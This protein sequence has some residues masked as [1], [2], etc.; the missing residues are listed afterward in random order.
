ML[1]RGANIDRK[2][3]V[4]VRNIHD[5]IAMVSMSKFCHS[6]MLEHGR[7][8]I[9]PQAQLTRLE[10]AYIPECD[11]GARALGKHAF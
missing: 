1:E 2:F 5:S 10:F 4:C 3:E 9:S 8:C 7:G 6:D 11:C